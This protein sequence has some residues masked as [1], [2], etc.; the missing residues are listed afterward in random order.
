MSSSRA[1]EDPQVRDALVRTAVDAALRAGAQYAD[2]QITH[3]MVQPCRFTN[4]DVIREELGV[5]VRALINGAWG[6]AAVPSGDVDA[7]KR[8]AEEATAQAKVNALGR[9][10]RTVLAPTPP[11]VGTWVMPVTIDPF[12]V[13][14]EEKLA[15]MQS[16]ETYAEQLGM[17]IDSITSELHFIRQERVVAT[18]EGA[19]FTQTVFESGGKIAVVER[20]KGTNH[21]ELVLL[22]GFIPAGKGWE[23]VLDAN[24]PEQLRDVPRRAA[25]QRASKEHPKPAQVGRYTIVCDGATMAALLDRTIG[26][27]TQLDR[28]MGYEAN[29]SG[30][31]FLNDPLA[32]LGSFKV[33][34]PLVTVTAN[35]SAPGQLA[36]VKWDDEGVA[37]QPFTLVNEGVLVDYQTTREQATWLAPYYQQTGQPVQSRGCAASENARSI[38]MQHMPNLGLTPNRHTASLDALVADVTDGIFIT[39]GTVSADFQA[40][41]GLLLGK[42]HEIKQGKIGRPLQGGGILFDTLDLWR[43]V[44]AIGDASTQHVVASTTYPFNAMVDRITGWYPVKGE[45][46]QRTSYSIQGVAATI[47]KQALIDPQRK[48]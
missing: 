39:S 26:V 45:P 14:I 40:R 16:W 29:A 10:D 24:V 6:F 11:A 34:S 43:N 20:I 37:P 3:T 31:S 22:D 19:H 47:T 25:L 33:G 23:L 41:T 48:A 28:A 2:A 30:T 12:T 7:V 46:P 32:M 21:E 13:P 17:H 38:T 44:T 18:S 27:A 9:H 4:I 36:T 5:G 8:L 35:R 1:I 42:F 15:F